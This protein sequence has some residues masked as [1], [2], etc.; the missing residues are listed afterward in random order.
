MI[1]PREPLAITPQLEHRLQRGELEQTCRAC[2]RWQAA[3]S[4]CSWC[5]TPIDPAD[6]YANGDTAQR[7]MR[8]PKAKPENPPLE[9]RSV[10]HWPHAWGPCPYRAQQRQTPLE[11]QES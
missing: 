2:G 6:W 5:L 11:A 9:Y 8:M 10:A 7:R 1:H 4:Y 3:C